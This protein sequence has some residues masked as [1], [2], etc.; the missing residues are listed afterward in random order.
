M[1]C[2]DCIHCSACMHS[3]DAARH[4]L[5]TRPTDHETGYCADWE[6]VTAL[7]NRAWLSKLSD[8]QLA[9]FLT[10][11]LFCNSIKNPSYHGGVSINMIQ[12][13]NIDSVEA[14]YQWLKA[15]QEFEVMK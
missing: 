2:K 11:G 14:V 1:T 6:G 13:R 8:K 12:R 9:G 15:D 10:Y 3:A 7:T 5:Y 4:P